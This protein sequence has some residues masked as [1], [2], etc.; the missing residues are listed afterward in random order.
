MGC[1]AIGA[2]DVGSGGGFAG[3]R[4]REIRRSS[5]GG[6]RAIRSLVES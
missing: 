5:G 4:S 6:A 1:A 2:T 3:I